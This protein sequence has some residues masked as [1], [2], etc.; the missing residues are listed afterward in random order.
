MHSLFTDR[1]DWDDEMESFE[2][3]WPGFFDVLRIYL[4]DFPGQ[5]AAMAFAATGHPGD[6]VAAWTEL[7]SAMG[8][9]GLDVGHRYETPSGVPHLVG[10]VESVHQTTEFRTVMVRLD[11]PN[12]GIALIGGCRPG[13]QSR[14]SVGLYLYGD[15]ACD[16]AAA[17]APRWQSWL[18]Q[19]GRAAQPAG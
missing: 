18:A 11:A 14:L 17:E 12:P 13:D 1:D 6:M 16:T 15:A 4:R 10:T 5:P 2:T 9:A 19:L 3:G 8:V 7:A